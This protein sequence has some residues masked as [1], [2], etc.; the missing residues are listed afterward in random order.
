MKLTKQQEKDAMKVYESYWDN[1]LKGNV[2]SMANLLDDDYTQIG[3]AETEVFFNKKDAVQFLY[4]TIDQVSGKLEMRNRSTRLEQ[5]GNLV[6]VHELC[7]IYVLTENKWVFYSKARASTLIQHKKEGWKF[8]HQHS[9]FPDART[10]E[11]ENI[12]IDKIAEE[13]REL[14]EAVKRRTVELENK[15]REL[16]IETSLERVRSS[17]LAMKKP[18]DMLDVCRIISDQLQSLGVNEIRNVQTAIFYETK[19]T[20]INFEYYTK[21]SKPVITEVDYRTHELQE[22]FASKM[23]KGVEELFSETLKNKELKDWYA[24]QKTTNQFADSF[25]E[26]AESL[27]YYWYSLGPVALGMSTYVPLNEQEINLFKRFRNVFEL[28]YRRFIDIQQAE[29]QARE[30]KIEASLERVRAVAMSMHK[31]KDLLNVSEIVYMELYKLGFNEMRN[32]M[33]NIHND[34]N[35]TFRNYDYSDEIGKSITLLNF[36]THPVMEKQIRQSRIANDAFSE[37][38]YEGKELEEWKEFRRKY[39][40]KDDPRIDKI[41]ALYYY[42]YSIGT[43]TIGISTFSQIDEQK[44]ILL[45]RFRNVFSLAYQR[46]SDIALAEA[47]ARESQIE[48]AL[49]RV[50]ARTMAMQH[51]EELLQVIDIV[52][53]QFQFL[54]FN[55]DNVSFAVRN[56]AHDYKFWISA[57]GLPHPYQIHVPYLNNPMFERIRNVQNNNLNI[58]TDTL[59]I[60]ESRQWHQHVFENS[61]FKYLPE[62][63]KHY[64]LNNNYTRTIVFMPTIMLIIGNYTSLLYT[65]EE[66][67]IFKRF[68]VVFEQSYTR[69]L[70][71]KKAEAQAREAQIEAALERVR[72]RTMGMQKSEEL[73]EVIRVVY[74]QFV[75]LKIN[76]DHAGFVVDYKPKGDWH[77]WIADEQEIP[78][79]ITHPYF[80]SVWANQFNEAKEKECR[81]LCHQFKF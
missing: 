50:R 77:F 38:V 61:I 54:N 74:E 12:A 34:E 71:L 7:D 44:L 23:I 40:E 76:V 63:T 11:G 24:Y 8:V 52:S 46:Y 26:T 48:L 58:Y 53:K 62:K 39:G 57:S 75:H 18:E 73:K 3:S 49:E 80:E 56:Q 19:K 9:S 29:A 60:E 64:I 25:L 33:I 45:K 51:S 27:S 10:G 16:E 65:E 41:K 78:S 36:N 17:A 47:Q 37:A 31:S 69:F 55:F 79:K 43:G 20:Y 14:R 67:N 5:Q 32:A 72:S 35:K 22:L 4:D 1:Y 2:E 42:F 81:L 66:N 68:A 30:A 13:N 59:S 15:S 6:L 70:D 28:A 21:H